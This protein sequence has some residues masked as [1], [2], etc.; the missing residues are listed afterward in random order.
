MERGFFFIIIII[1]A[2]LYFLLSIYSRIVGL[3]GVTSRRGI[4]MR[5]VCL[6]NAGLVE[7]LSCVGFVE[8]TLV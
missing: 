7:G 1:S 2:F 6:G 5:G 8:G 3:V 4:V